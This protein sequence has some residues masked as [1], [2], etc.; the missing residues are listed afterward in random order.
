MWCAHPPSAAA[1]ALASSLGSGSGTCRTIMHVTPKR[2]A[3][4]KDITGVSEQGSSSP[5]AKS[6]PTETRYLGEAS[7]LRR[8]SQQQASTSM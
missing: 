2:H 8:P 6:S 5:R 3:R 4:T 1:V 7:Q